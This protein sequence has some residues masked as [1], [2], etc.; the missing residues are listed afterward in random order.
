MF[1]MLGSRA[2]CAQRRDGSAL[3]D[4]QQN[5]VWSLS[6]ATCTRRGSGW[7]FAFDGRLLQG[8]HQTCNNTYSRAERIGAD[9]DE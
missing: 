3:S 7:T 6:S 9:L 8:E 4:K 2:R 1:A 5:L